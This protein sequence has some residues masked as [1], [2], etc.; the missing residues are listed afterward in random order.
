MRIALSM[1]KS[2]IRLDHPIPEI[3]ETL[4]LL[5]IE[6]DAVINETS[7][8]SG[9]VVGEILTAKKHP[10]AE[11]LTIAEVS[12]GKSRLQ[13]VCAAE[14]C[15]AG[16]KTALAKVG[17]SVKDADGKRRTIEK[18]SLRGAE[19]SGMLCSASDLLI[20]DDASRIL[21]LPTEWENGQDLAPL[22][23]DPVLEVSL[24][25]NL[26]H[27]YSALGI[28]R[29]LG[30]ALKIP[31]HAPK[32]SLRENEDSILEQKV[33]AT[34]H[35]FALCPRYMCRL[36][37]GASIGPS[38]FWLQKELRSC[39]MKPINNA[40][41][42][43]NYIMIKFG[44]PLH[45][46]D[47][48]RIEGS[49]IE[50]AP[51]DT[52]QKFLCLDGIEREISP[53]TLLVS[54]GK[55]PVA[56]AG[57]IGGENSAVNPKTKT[58][59]LEAAFFDPMTIRRGA[60]RLGLRTES[61]IRFEKGVDPNGVETSLDEAARLIAE[62]CG[63]CIAKGRIDLKKG[64]F[65]PKRIRCR[66]DRVNH[67]LGT[68]LSQTE[69]EEIFQRLGFKTRPQE[70]GEI[71]VEVPAYRFDVSEEIDL[72]EEAA[73]IYGYNNIEKGISRFTASQIP[74]DPAHLFEREYRSRCIGLGL[75]EFLT[76]DLI[77]PKLADLALEFAG[78]QVSL[79][80]A[81]HAKTEEYSIL[82]P[83][84]LPGLLQAAKGNIDQKN[85]NLA[86]FEIGRIHFLQ[87]GEPVEI[88][89]GAF[90]LSGKSSPAHW[91]SKAEEACFYNLKGILET[92][93]EG[94]KI[95]GVSFEPSQHLSFHPGRQANIHCDSLIIGSLGEVHPALLAKLD[96]KQRI[97]FAEIH[98]EHL[99]KLH[100]PKT[101]MAPIPQFPSSERDWTVS[102]S[103]K[104]LI[105]TLFDAIHAIR[106]PLLEKV[107]LI[108]LYQPEGEQRKNATLRF[109]YRDLLKTISAEEV[110]AEHAKILG[111]VSASF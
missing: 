78:P 91:S 59:L 55:K 33:E 95:S 52:T 90:L 103:P 45:A 83:S 44:Q 102:L 84:L 41:D 21:E 87:K 67:L 36:I 43:A 23:W 32:V 100:K 60:K 70:K 37:E 2:F 110:E 108:D 69:V 53:G 97:L 18:A 25:P 14:N 10:N 68:K 86:A 71:A 76:S 38:P 35:D 96:I 8:F 54:D 46:F 106:S 85:L 75:Q 51:S 15:R 105:E 22:L 79:L 98:L 40:V 49:S 3:C 58:I 9:V 20:W 24:T 101:Q 94:L 16:I 62:V 42:A 80:K 31:V 48:D 6:V 72:V 29:E 50:I 57:V 56:A 77:S 82:R 111:S 39:G 66:I 12:D 89:M 27:C 61:A 19:S 17:A 1:L 93:F 34:V 65:P 30:A 81:I 63:G 5:G 88:P 73:R 28:A 104:T 47:F 92:L 109:T 99:R 11:K 64:P 74:S 26:G 4:T 13:I 7:P 107:E